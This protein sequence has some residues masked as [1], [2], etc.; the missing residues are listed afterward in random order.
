MRRLFTFFFLIW[1][2]FSLCAQGENVKVEY[3]YHFFT[4]RGYEVNRPMILTF[5]NNKSKFY[6]PDTNR[7]DSICSTPEGRAEYE[8]Y[9]NS[10][11]WSRD[12]GQPK[13]IRWEKMY[14]EKDRKNN[15]L[16]VYD[17]VAGEDFYNYTEPLDGMSWELTDSVADILGYSCQMAECDYHGRR[18]TAW[19]TTEIPVSEGPWKLH[20]LPGLILKA[21]EA[22][23][24]Y[25]FTA[26][27]LEKYDND[28]EPVYQKERYEK[29]DRK[30]LYQTKR[31]ID[32]NFGGFV[33]AQTGVAM[34]ANMKSTKMKEGYD[35]IETDYR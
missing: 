5:S 34:P 11:D 7:I 16:T 26:T 30:E 6:N 21:I 33:S 27:G 9:V 22:D 10:I 4:P 28:I 8:A 25:E 17:T 32:G 31:L 29:I 20:G 19:F 35:Y 3:D 2:T 12:K 23:G 15:E 13:L 18:W 1:I 14:V 24:V